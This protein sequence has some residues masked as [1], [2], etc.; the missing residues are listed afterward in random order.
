MLATA[1]LAGCGME[2]IAPPLHK[3]GGGSLRTDGGDVNLSIPALYVTQA[4]QTLDGDVP[5]LAGRSGLLRV[6]V[7]AS[8]PHLAPPPVRVRFYDG[9][10]LVRTVE[11]PPPPQP[12]PTAI[13]EASLD[14]SWNL[15]LDASLLRPGLAIVADVDPGDVVPESS[16]SD[17]VWPPAGTPVHLD[18]RQAPP[19][20]LRFVPVLQSANGLLGDISSA[21]AEPFLAL[22]RALLPLTEVHA[23]VRAPFTTSAP[24]VKPNNENGAWSQILNELQALRLAEG[25]A[26]HYYGVIKASYG[27]GVAGVAY[28][29]RGIAVG[30]DHPSS[31]PRVLAHE[32]GHTFGRGHTPCGLGSADPSYPYPDGV[33]GAYGF[34]LLTRTVRAPDAPDLM[35]YC[36]GVWI[37]DYTYR[38]ILDWREQRAGTVASALMVASGPKRPGLLVWG[39]MEPDRLVLEPAYE[40]EAPASLPAQ[41]GPDL[42]EGFGAD[43]ARLFSLAFT[44]ERVIDAPAAAR[45]FAFVVPMELLGGLPLARLRLTSG[46]AS[47]ERGASGG[48]LDSAAATRLDD[49]T[50][51]V[52]WLSSAVQ[53]ALIRDAATGDI[54]AFG[55]DGSADVRTLGGVLEL[56]LSDGVRT[57][58][59][60]ITP[61]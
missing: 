23:D 34:D 60:T 11:I 5:L 9:Y 27:S 38:G 18:V 57:R 25:S 59:Q 26:K 3:A 47:V 33:I 1:A 8:R 52:V 17:N 24:A 20:E 16:E 13:R 28:N 4:V 40:V 37:S 49:G 14:A 42:I 55:R 31:G 19:L 22:T 6:F 53:G 36:P 58:V 15:E 61:H 56:H 29:G 41:P 50:V 7:T 48:S 2:A 12:V 32:L 54:L 30:W 43:G 46:G 44:A 45:S 51:R 39:R 35:G 21:N 10:Q